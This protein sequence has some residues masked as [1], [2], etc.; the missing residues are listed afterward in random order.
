MIAQ[1]TKFSTLT[2]TFIL[3][4]EKT[5]RS[6]SMNHSIKMH[7]CMLVTTATFTADILCKY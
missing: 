2:K 1:V 4:L 7:V 6:K 5:S 3:R